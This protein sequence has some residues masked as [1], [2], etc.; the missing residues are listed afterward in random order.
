MQHYL[1]CPISVLLFLLSIDSVAK[2]WVLGTSPSAID[3]V[4]IKKENL[5]ETHHFNKFSG[6]IAS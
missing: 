5:S 4:S 1:T 6:Y 3:F 2:N